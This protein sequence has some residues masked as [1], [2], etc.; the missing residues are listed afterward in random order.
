MAPFEWV[1]PLLYPHKN[2][3]LIFVIE[4]RKLAEPN[5]E[6]ERFYLNN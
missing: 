4:K 5:Y 1:L 3:F 2:D 6:Y